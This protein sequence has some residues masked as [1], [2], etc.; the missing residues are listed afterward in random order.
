MKALDRLIIKAKQKYGTDL[1]FYF[2]MVYPS[3][4]QPGKWEARGDLWNHT[5]YDKPGCKCDSVY[6]VCD[7]IEEAAAALQ[8]LSEKYPNSKDVSIIIDDLDQ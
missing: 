4:K 6:Y 8:E 3:W 5:E 1:K 2:G 7:S